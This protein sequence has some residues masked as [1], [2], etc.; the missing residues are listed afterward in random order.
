MGKIGENVEEKSDKKM[1]NRFG[2][3]YLER[4]FSG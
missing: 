3:F 4:D 1:T 2:V